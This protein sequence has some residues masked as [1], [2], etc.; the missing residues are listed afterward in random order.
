MSASALPPTV[1][2]VECLDDALRGVPRSKRP[3][4]RSR[5]CSRGSTGRALEPGRPPRRVPQ[6][7]RA[8][9]AEHA[10]LG[11]R[12]RWRR[13][14]RRA[15]WAAVDLA[16]H[17]AGSEK[18]PSTTS[19]WPRII[20]ASG[21]QRKET[22][23]AMSSGSTSRPAG[24]RSADAEHLLAVREVLERAGL[25]DAA[26]DGVDADPARRELDGEVADDRLERR[27]RRADEHVVLEHALRAEARDRDDRGAVAASRRGRARE[28][29]QR[30]GVRVHRPVP[31]LVL[32]LERRPDDAGGG[33]VDEDV[34]RAE[35]RDLLD[36]LRLT[37][38]C[39]ARAPAL[40][41]P[42]GSPPRPP[43]RPC[44]CGGSRS[45]PA[46]R[47]RGEAER[48]RAADPARA[49]GHED[50]RAL[51]RSSPS[52]AA[53]RRRGARN[54]RPAGPRP[55][56]A[57]ALLRPS[58]TRGRAGRAAP[59]SPRRSGGRGGPR[60][61]PR[62]A[63][64]PARGAGTRSAA[65]RARRGRRCLRWSARPRSKPNAVGSA[66]RAEPHPSDADAASAP[67]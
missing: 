5:G 61:G 9:V 49:A 60:A 23:P 1:Q 25:D 47:R 34:E 31:V 58:R 18:P 27:L 50:G 63:R 28:R 11:P 66:V 65:S 8:A 16:V 52:G 39:R 35:R 53:R 4:P 24:V 2:V 13:S 22:A 55:R 19:V 15:V 14:V 10:A 21:E 46:R 51:E 42:R 17:Q 38:R 67:S 40:R 54:L 26:G 64:G 57:A 41:R 7:G 62:R 30:P 32:G 3:Y 56:L 20:S 6:C 44:R 48:D 59:S 43:R 45:R 36:D 29:E 33:V 37:R 12:R